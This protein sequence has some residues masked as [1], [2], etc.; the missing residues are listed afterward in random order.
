MRKLFLTLTALLSLLLVGCGNSSNG[1]SSTPI[2]SCVLID[3]DYD[4]DDLMAIPLVIGNAHV[5][6]VI[7]S[8]GYTMPQESS[9]NLQALFAQAGNVNIPVITGASS[10]RTDFSEWPWLAFFR[11][12]MNVSN[13]LFGTQ[14]T[15]NSSQNYTQQV[16]NVLS[17]C[18]NVSVLIIGTYTSFINYSPAIQ[19]KIDK[20]V[21]MG[22]NVDDPTA[23]RPDGTVNYSFNCEYDM[24]ACLT[25]MGQLK[26]LNTVFVDI[27]KNTTPL[28]EPS[29][30]M[31]NALVTN[32]LPG[33]LK[34]ALYN[35]YNCSSFYTADMPIISGT[36]CTSESTWVPADV[37]AGPGGHMYLWDETAAL[38]LINPS[39]FSPVGGHVEPTVINGSYQETLNNLQALWTQD[40]N[41]AANPK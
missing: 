12:A 5:A 34:N 6:A 20:V 35:S 17:Q 36:P 15:P 18:Q 10:N 21:I 31:V 8:E 9:A 23:I 37:A 19:S 27:P 32:G 40:T 41:N 4:I 2:P 22:K 13:G 3:T 39:A 25:A 33:V 16:T 7:T 1:Q 11:S 29:T 26:N 24:P 28:Y 14:P 38:Y 30:A